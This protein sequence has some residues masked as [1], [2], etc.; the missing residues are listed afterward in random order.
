MN[1]PISRPEHTL[2]H[3]F[4]EIDRA[5]Q[6]VA[7][8]HRALAE[9]Q[10]RADAAQ[11]LQE[12]AQIQL[13]NAEA[14]YSVLARSLELAAPDLEVLQ[15]RYA[16]RERELGLIQEQLEIVRVQA[17]TVERARLALRELFGNIRDLAAAA[18]SA[19]DAMKRSVEDVRRVTQQPARVAA[20]RALSDRLEDQHNELHRR[21]TEYEPALPE[22]EAAIETLRVEVSSAGYQQALVTRREW[23][24]LDMAETRNE[25]AAKQPAI[26]LDE[27]RRASDDL[28]AAKFATEEAPRAVRRAQADLKTATEVLTQT[29][30][31]AQNAQSQ[32]DKL[33]AEFVADIEL[34]APNA[35][36]IVTARAQF[37]QDLPAGYTLRW[38]AGAASVKPEKGLAT[39]IDTSQL[40]VGQ[41]IVEA[42]LVRIAPVA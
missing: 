31:Q 6:L 37:N 32:L 30:A 35:A 10:K 34:S 8:Q 18:T 24:E 27:L 17:E 41:T 4:D 38:Q 22:L 20:F 21:W 36:G 16:E 23:L 15:A 11:A 9:V 33:E 28:E 1:M 7:D 13:K 26:D 39:N 19:M 3:A 12:A 14:K 40:P 5:N 42:Q 2:R 29:Q 25:L